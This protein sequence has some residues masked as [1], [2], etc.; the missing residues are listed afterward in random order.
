MQN[1]EYIAVVGLAALMLTAVAKAIK[2]ERGAYRFLIS[3]P[4]ENAF[5]RYSPIP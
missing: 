5:A 1:L 3:F 4:I 2:R